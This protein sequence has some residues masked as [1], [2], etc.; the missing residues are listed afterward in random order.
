MTKPLIIQE[1]EPPMNIVF[2]T[3]DIGLSQLAEFLADSNTSLVL[4]LDVETNVTNTF[5]PRRVRTIQLGNREKQFVIDLLAYA[6]NKLNIGW[7]QAKGV[8]ESLTGHYKCHDL[9]KPILDVLR[10]IL[11]TDKYIKV[12]HNI[13]FEYI[14]LKWCLGIRM[15]GMYCTML[16]ERVIYC[17]EYRFQAKGIWALDDLVGR[18]FGLEM[19]KDLQKSF[20]LATLLTKDQIDYAALDIRSVLSIRPR[21]LKR[22]EKE[23]LVKT[24][25]VENNAIGAFGD[26]HLNGLLLDAEPWLEYMETIKTKRDSA[27][28][29]LD[30]IFVPI[31]G[32]KNPPNKEPIDALE[33][34]WRDSPNKT[35]E[36]KSKRAENRKAFMATNQNYKAYFK[37][38]EKWVGKA[39]INYKS[40]K[41][42]LSALH[43]LGFTNKEM[44]NTNDQT[45]SRLAG[46]PVIDALRDL[47][48]HNKCL[49]TY[50]E[51]LIKKIDPDTGRLHSRIIQLGAETGRPSSQ[52]PNILNF[53]KVPEMRA[54]FIACPGHQILTIDTAGQ[55]LCIMAELSGEPKWL[56]ALANRWDIHS[57]CAEMMDEE[58]WGSQT[59]ADCEYQKE[60]KKC[61]CPGHMETRDNAKSLNFLIAYGGSKYKLAD[62]LN[63]AMETTKYTLSYAVTIMDKHKMAFPTLWKYLEDSGINAISNLESFSI[64]GRRRKYT[65]PTWPSATNSAKAKLKKNGKDRE[66]IDRE[67]RAAYGAMFGAIGREG[68]NMTIQ[69]SAADMLKISIGSGVDKKGKPFLWHELEPRF[70]AKLLNAPYDELVIEAKD[71]NAQEVFAFVSD[72]I[73]R[74]G[75]EFINKVVMTTEGNIDFCWKK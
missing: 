30:D 25:E 12:G 66:P 40:P 36:D 74:A 5:F 68:R 57:L 69:G 32:E 26:M 44:D 51:K 71:E 11:E 48:K 35:E 16:A 39:T 9:F 46:K 6:L 23:G 29:I 2:V 65:Q 24:I 58:L 7:D 22:I 54:C 62:N 19:S 60:K 63:E 61:K 27:I 41:Q 20:D 49:D 64:V 52:E 59:L 14:M 70:G 31:V 56:E 73:T 28:E 17:G 38:M 1:L 42:L 10:P 15:W 45:L 33:K 43:K 13:E 50:G 21:Q 67:I 53:P 37:N 34:A 3:D 18:Y 47:R 8:L 55:E 75:A 4:G 72:C